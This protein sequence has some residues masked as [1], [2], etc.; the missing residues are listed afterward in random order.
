MAPSTL[1]VRGASLSYLLA[2][3]CMLGEWAACVACECDVRFYQVSGFG[4]KACARPGVDFGCYPGEDAMWIRPPCGSLFRCNANHH[5]TGQDP[6]IQRG[7]F[8]RCGSRYFKPEKGQTRLNC[9]CASADPH[10]PKHFGDRKSEHD[11]SCAEHLSIDSLGG[12]SNAYRRLPMPAG[13]NPA[14]TCCRHRQT[15]KGAI[16]S[17]TLNFTKRDFAAWPAACEALCDREWG[18]GCRYFTHSIRFQMCILC[19]A[20]EPEI[21]LG[22]DTFASFQRVSEDPTQ[23]YTGVLA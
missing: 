22:D 6:Y 8:L 23:L 1:L 9:S 17:N 21:A 19:A 15:S 10:K 14:V 18:R 2:A 7:G 16:S 5:D 20:C 3:V 4:N 13:A 12:V 11:G